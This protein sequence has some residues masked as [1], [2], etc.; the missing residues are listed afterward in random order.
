MTK[1]EN[2]TRILNKQKAD[3]T[4]W[5]P[6]FDH[7]LG[8]NRANNTVP[9]EYAGLERNDI[10]RKAGAS[11][12]ARKGI[13]RADWPN[14][15][16]I[17][18]EEPGN[19][20]RTIYETP[21]GTVETLHKYASDLTRA[22]FLKEHRIK[23]REDIGIVKF[24]VEDTVYTLD[25]QPFLDSE[26]EVGEDGISL[27]SLPVC[28]PYIQFGKNDAGW[29]NGIYLWHDYTE[30]VED[31]MEAYRRKSEEAARLI[32]AGP[33]LVVNSDDNMDQ[34]TTPP[35][36]FKKYAVPYYRSIA[37]IL[38]GG[39][40]LLQVHWCG[41]TQDL[42]P[43]VPETGID[44]VEAVTVKPMADLTIPE[45]LDKVGENVV[46]QGGIPSIMMCPQGC[47]RDEL[48]AY[49]KD[50]L[51]QVPL[52]YRYVVGMSDNV[53]PDADFYR[54]RMISDIVNS[55]DGTG[56]VF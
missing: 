51:G 21:V 36:I 8:V 27:V 49:V 11:I 39:G 14:V 23:N 34:W 53:P 48:A 42:L 47:T 55:L 20:I 45:A 3:V 38:H 37:K 56:A 32:A 24:I 7:W 52:G 26:R 33:A 16:I 41:R 28:V 31:L 35:S 9:V 4:V 19:F 6:N 50:L 25:P 30:E 44:V 13:I 1:R 40:K 10:V 46:I 12:W 29:E 18:Q 22:L 2:Y 15:N 17:R 54:V 5:A 43:L